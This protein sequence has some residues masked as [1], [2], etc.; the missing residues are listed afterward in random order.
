MSS[1]MLN[2]QDLLERKEFLER[3]L[4]ECD[5]KLANAPPG[6]LHVSC[7]NG[8]TQYYYR[9]KP[10]DKKGA[11]LRKEKRH[12]VSLLQQKDYCLHLHKTITQ[13]LKAIDAYLKYMPDMSAD[14]VYDRLPVYRRELTDP[15]IESDLQFMEKWKQTGFKQKEMPEDFE[16]YVT[17]NEEIVRS[18]SELI[19][20]NSLKKADIPYRYECPLRLR[21]IGIVHPDFT[22]LDIRTKQEVYWEHLG[23]M[24]DPEYADKA[25]HKI[26][27]YIKNGFCPGQRLIVTMETQACHINTHA[28][29]DMIETIFRKEKITDGSL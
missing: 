14:D 17:E 9:E 23:M 4:E 5:R 28:I 24:D 6:R 2:V 1:Q 19:I 16:G 13:E 22:V 25:V 3:K 18:K 26:N 7:S 15:L 10:S 8:R 29:R 21:G 27:A 12:L 20:A 11:Y